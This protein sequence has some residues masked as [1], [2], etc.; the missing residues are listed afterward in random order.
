MGRLGSP[1]STC[2]AQR[3]MRLLGQ[4]PG[5][6]EQSCP[7]TVYFK[8]I[9]YFFACKPSQLS[10]RQFA[11]CS[12]PL[13]CNLE[14][15]RRLNDFPFSGDSV[16]EKREEGFVNDCFPFSEVLGT[17]GCTTQ[18]VARFQ[19]THLG[20][21]FGESNPNGFLCKSFFPLL[22]CQCYR[23]LF[24]WVLIYALDTA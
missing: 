12:L 21:P 20:L 16:M 10:T 3:F 1:D 2:Q 17:P 23:A 9:Y 19:G 5:V 24:Y 14:M 8:V 18:T 7:Q 13:R 11:L 6:S 22:T 4:K 15:Q